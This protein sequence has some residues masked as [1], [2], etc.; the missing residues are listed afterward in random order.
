[1]AQINFRIDEDTKE[2]AEKFFSEIGMSMSTAITIFLR[3][4][5]REQRI[6]FEITTDPFYSRENIERLR[7]SAL[8]MEQTGGTIHNIEVDEDV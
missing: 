5:C 6:P 1:M 7:R 2:S 4:V 8:Q 3:T